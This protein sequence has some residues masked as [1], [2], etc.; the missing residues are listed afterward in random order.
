MFLFRASDGYILLDTGL[1]REESLKSLE[2]ALR[3]LGLSWSD[4]SEILIS[5]LHPDHLGAAAE[6]RRRSG[7][8][9]R[10]PAVESE[11]VRPLAPHQEFF[12]DTAA[13]LARHGMP[14]SHVG[15][16]RRLANSHRGQSERL[17]VDGSI[18]PGERVDFGGGTLETVSAPGHSPGLL[19]F[20]CPQQRTLFSTDVVLP[21]VTPNI[22][23][24]WFY[25]GNPLG[26]YMRTLARLKAFDVEHIAP[27]HGRPFT[28]LGEWIESTRLHHVR[29]CNVILDSMAD[30]PMSAYEIAIA[31][32][33]DDRSLP[34][35][36]FAMSEALA[37]LE[38]MA[39]Q[40]RV[41]ETEAGGLAHWRRT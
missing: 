22:G 9:V 19:C 28:G 24:H 3:S 8:P 23:V 25:Q 2:A 12:A 14:R 38:F 33:G 16:L 11:Y 10:M 30:R 36:R 17:V 1:K 4:I 13:F 34:D 31:V 40:R 26:D 15:A 32:W 37:H 27:S 7:A 18:D 39:R 5:H 20:Y 41:E 35:R 29:R 6:I 21:K